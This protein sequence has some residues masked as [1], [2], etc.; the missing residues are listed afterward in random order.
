M[1]RI[2]IELGAWESA[3]CPIYT[4]KVDVDKAEVALFNA[5]QA[6]WGYSTTEIE[7]LLKNEE[8]GQKYEKFMSRLCEEEENIII[9]FGGKYYEDMSDEEYESIQ[10]K[11]S[12]CYDVKEKLNAFKAEVKENIVKL[13]TNIYLIHNGHFPQWDKDEE[14]VVEDSEIGS[15]SYISVEMNYASSTTT[16][17][18][19]IE[20]YHINA[21][22]ELF[23]WCNDTLEEVIWSDASAEELVE[24]STKLSNYWRKL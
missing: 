7:N 9:E 17:L 20:E 5:M 13:L 1:D 10:E 19:T 15:T 8:K 4:E 2:E 24:I 18:W 23:F 12:I 6:K 3:P 16:E 21:S 22:G 14:L 11:D